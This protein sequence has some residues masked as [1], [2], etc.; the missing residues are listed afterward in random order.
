MSIRDLHAAFELIEAN[1]NLVCFSGPQPVARLDRAQAAL[2]FEFPPSYLEFL[3]RLGAGGV[4]WAEFYGVVD[5][6]FENSCVP[7]AIWLTLSDRKEGDLPDGY[8]VVGSTGDGG[9]YAIDVSQRDA[10]G[11]SPVVE[12]WPGLP[13]ADNNPRA[14]ASDFG[15]FFRQE[16][17]GAIEHAKS[18]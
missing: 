18:D 13:D 6:D 9:V 10:D 14:I 2:G 8:V 1:R 17:T 4:G 11:E 12:W 5:D 16:I 7:D 3:A 15:A